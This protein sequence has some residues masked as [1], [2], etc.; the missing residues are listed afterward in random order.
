M[1]TAVEAVVAPIAELLMV[2]PEM[3]SA[4]AISSSTQSKPI[5][6]PSVSAVESTLPL[7]E[8]VSASEMYAFESDDDALTRPAMAWRGPVR[9]FASCVVLETVRFD[10]VAVSE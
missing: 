8:M 4:S 5:V 1:N 10:V 7:D 3:V 9:L 6:P 2:P